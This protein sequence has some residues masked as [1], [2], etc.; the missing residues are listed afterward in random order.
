MYISG[1]VSAN[2][3]LIRGNTQGG[4]SGLV[5]NTSF[6]QVVRLFSLLYARKSWLSVM[7]KDFEIKTV[8]PNTSQKN[9]NLNLSPCSIN[10]NVERLDDFCISL[11]TAKPQAP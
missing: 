4:G 5:F 10:S 8:N 9:N 6:R 2:G 7:I 11:A 1:Q 3:T